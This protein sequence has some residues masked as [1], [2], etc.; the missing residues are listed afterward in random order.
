MG[1]RFFEWWNGCL[2]LVRTQTINAAVPAAI[3][4]NATIAPRKI[5]KESEIIPRVMMTKRSVDSGDWYKSPATN[6]AGVLSLKGWTLW[7]TSSV[8]GFLLNKF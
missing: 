2:Q 6:Q 1:R 4:M 8:R 7:E 5:H 3:I